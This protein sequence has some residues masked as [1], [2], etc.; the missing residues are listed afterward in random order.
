MASSWSDAR[1]GKPAPDFKTTAMVD[2]AFKDVKL[3]GYKGKYLVLFFYPL[4][5]TFVCPMEIIA[6]SN[7][8]K[9]F[10]KLGCEMLSWINTQPQNEGGLGPLNIPLLADVTRRLS[11]GYSVLKT[12]EGTAYRGLV[13]IDG[14]DV[15]CEITVSDLPVGPS[16]DQALWLV[17][18]IQYMEEPVL[19]EVCPPGWRPGSDTMKP[20]VDDSKE[21]FS[22]HNSAG[23]RI[24]SLYPYLGAC[25]VCPPVPPPGC[26]VL[27]QERPDLPLHTPQS[28]TLEG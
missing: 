5:F 10:C 6:F 20:S 16:V 23:Q 21:Y 26:P 8:A 2:G 17:Q 22:K 4:D 24:V 11:E 28:G 12:H 7:Q 13:I 9:D 15:L 19:R 25:A 27:T 1:I 3:S 18:T 14:K